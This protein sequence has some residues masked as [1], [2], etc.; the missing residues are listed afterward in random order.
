VYKVFA[1]RST[2]TNQVRTIGYTTSS[3][4]AKRKKLLQQDQT[5]D[6]LYY[7]SRGLKLQGY[8][9]TIELIETAASKTEAQNKADQIIQDYKNKAHPLTNT[10][11][12]RTKN[13]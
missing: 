1:L 2:K 3:L 12:D 9:L 8:T 5:F 10:D 13:N 7:L 6:S 4:P 11:K